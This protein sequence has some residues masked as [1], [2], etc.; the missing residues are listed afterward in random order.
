VILPI[1]VALYLLGRKV[2]GFH[3][4]EKFTIIFAIVAFTVANVI[5]LWSVLAG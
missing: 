4:W 3:R 2:G 5:F 1:L